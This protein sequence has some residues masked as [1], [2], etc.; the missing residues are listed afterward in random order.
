MQQ[1]RNLY[2]AQLRDKVTPSARVVHGL[3]PRASTLANKEWVRPVPAA[4][5]IPALRVATTFTGPKASV[6]G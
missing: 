5:V 1:A 6:A 4:A 3:L 2:N